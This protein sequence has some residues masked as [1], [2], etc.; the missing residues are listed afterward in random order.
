M[1]LV[2]P[3]HY[4]KYNV[5]SIDPG[6]YSLGLSVWTIDYLEARLVGI[7]S[8]TIKPERL[9]FSDGMPEPEVAMWRRLEIMRR[10]YTDYLERYQPVRVVYETP[11]FNRRTPGAYKPL[12]ACTTMIE[13]ATMDYNPAI[14][15]IGIPPL[16]VK[17]AV[18]ATSA[19]GK[20]PMYNAVRDSQ[21]IQSRL[22]TP[23]AW[24]D[25]HAIDSLAVGVS[26]V[27]QYAS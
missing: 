20:N 16:L 6:T 24:L 1:P 23:W 14:Q 3:E 5:F 10:I 7:E 26:D 27:S 11:F 25:E 17:Q 12:L 18:N 19:K 9:D 21:Y 22:L 8:S 13:R 2:V 15:L 4:Y